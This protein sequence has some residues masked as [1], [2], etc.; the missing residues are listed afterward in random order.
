MSMTAPPA[1]ALTVDVEGEWYELPG[2]QGFFDLNKVLVAVKSLEALLIRIES[3]TATRIPVTWFIRCDDSVAVTTGRAEGLL[4]SLDTFVQRRL[5]LGDQFGLHPHLYRFNEGNWSSET[6]PEKQ[7][8]QIHRAALAWER[9]FGALPKLSRMGEAVMNNVIAAT[10]DTLGIQMDSSALAG[11]SRFDNGFQ[12]DWS[13]TPTQP[14]YPAVADYRRPASMEEPA[15]RFIEAPFSML[16]IIGPH[17]REPIK[18]YC[19]LAFK[20]SLV[21]SALRRIDRPGHLIMV[22]HPHELLASKYSHP[23]ISHDPASLQEN[24]HHLGQ[25]FGS[26]NFCLL[27]DCMK[28]GYQ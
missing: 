19:N 17:D 27:S 25:V 22:V 13:T 1:M 5:D 21:G 8:E 2:E 28:H 7:Q 4:Q 12:F 3:D 26:L 18:R 9:H 14:Y 16:P 6:T 23:L 24:I 20:S 10:L 11:R 15:H